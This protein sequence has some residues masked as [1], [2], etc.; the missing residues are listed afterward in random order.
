MAVSPQD[1]EKLNNEDKL[2]ADSIERKV[3]QALLTSAR[4]GGNYIVVV[5]SNIT[6]KAFADIR[7]RY[8]AVGWKDVV[9]NFAN[10]DGQWI[11]FIK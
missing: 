3:D 6:L 5:H 8:L 11:E 7:D 9:L 2:L 1:I 4:V 10:P